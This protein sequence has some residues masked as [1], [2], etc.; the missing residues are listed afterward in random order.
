MKINKRVII[1]VLCIA[2]V[3][4]T[5]IIIINRRNNRDLEQNQ[6]SNINEDANTIEEIKNEI[7]ATADTNMYQI[8]Q[9]YDG[10]KIIQIKPNIQ[11]ETVLAGILK[12][13]MPKEEEIKILLEN[14]PIKSG[15][16][17]SKQSREKF[18]K[19][20][21]DNNI[22]GYEID[23]EGYLVRKEE[24][25]NE[26]LKKAINSNKLYILDISGKCYDRDDISGEIVEYPFE[27]MEPDQVLEIYNIENS[28]ILEI[29]TNSRGI[30]SNKEILDEI[31]LNLE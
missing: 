1:I 16:W 15:V 2:I 31:L 6:I 8:E 26:T 21:K 9:E 17:I 20:L 3:V 7:N 23:K 14:R 18:I 5:I 4:A 12:N 28:A 27:E 24:I 13:S 19:I 22:K 25:N 29:T 10:R 11:Y 30:L